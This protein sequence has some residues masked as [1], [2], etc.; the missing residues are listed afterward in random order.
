MAT[1]V[2]T[3]GSGTIPRAI[4]ARQPILTGALETRGYELLYQDGEVGTGAP[5]DPVRATS[6]LLAHI[7]LDLGLERVAGR[8]PAW[9][10]FPVE[11]LVGENP[12]PVLPSGIVVEL[13][14][15]L[16]GDP[17]LLARLRKLK[18]S[19]YAL[20]LCLFDQQDLEIGA[21]LAPYLE[22]A[23]YVKV[24]GVGNSPE[25]IATTVETLRPL[26]VKVV[27]TGVETMAEY[28]VCKAAGCDLFQGYFVNKPTLSRSAK[29]PPNRIALVRLLSEM[30][31]AEPNL[32]RIEALV[33]QDVG[34][35]YNLL[36]ALN[37]SLY[38]LPRRVESIQHAVM[39]L[40]LG[41]L[42][43]LVGVLLVNQ[44]TDRPPELVETALTRA[45]TLER[46][47]QSAGLVP[48]S[49][50]AVGLLSVLDAMLE[51]PMDRVLA[52]VP[53]SQELQQALLER[54]GSYGRLLRAKEAH[55][56]AAHDEVLRNGVDP[57]AL[58]LAWLDAVTWARTVQGSLSEKS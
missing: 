14:D 32:R 55:E 50:F 20:A 53:L 31:A 1:D 2:V 40:G 47:A 8:V 29:T 10:R 7:L 13:V 19:S 39:L 42:R 57:M 41:R 30:H 46:L 44:I 16:D 48:E 15:G 9:V 45:K 51:Q 43:N 58:T 38:A 28:E 12:I 52:Q 4:L 26:G 17:L 6:T 25:R 24:D 33:S 36:R 21:H 11:Y 5:P 3:R 49:G 23:T 18:E 35:T 27:A 37:S 54:T 34:L 22:L 56:Q